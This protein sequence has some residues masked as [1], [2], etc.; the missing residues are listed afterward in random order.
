MDNIGKLMLICVGIMLSCII[1]ICLTQGY[2]TCRFD[3]CTMYIKD[4]TKN[5][6]STDNCT[7][8]ISYKPNSYCYETC[9]FDTCP[10]N[11]T[12][13]YTGKWTKNCDLDNKCNVFATI[14]FY[15]SIVVLTISGCFVAG[16][17]ALFWKPVH[18]VQTDPIMGRPVNF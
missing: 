1:T 4:C 3:S 15:L 6:S 14:V 18:D 8:V 12:Q 9:E 13:C 16:W 7:L 11:N 5:S 2:L 17:F 10:K